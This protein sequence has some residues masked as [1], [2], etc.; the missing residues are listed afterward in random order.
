MKAVRERQGRSFAAGSW[1]FHA[2][3]RITILW[4]TVLFDLDGTLID[5]TEG[6]VRSVQYALGTVGKTENDLRNLRR[7]LGAPLREAFQE[8]AGL[9]EEEAG[10]ASEA[11]RDYFSRDGMYIASVYPGIPEMLYALKRAG[12]TLG[13]VTSKETAQAVR[14]LQQLQLAR[15]FDVII[16]CRP[17]ETNIPKGAL[18][19]E[20][21]NVL[22]KQQLRGEVVFVGDRF[23]DVQAAHGAGIAAAG[24]SYGYGTAGELAQSGADCVA[25]NVMGL[26]Q[27]LMRGGQMVSRGNAGAPMTTGQKILEVM[28]PIL[29]WLAITNIVSLIGGGIY[30]V[31][32]VNEYITGGGDV[33]SAPQVILQEMMQSDM[34]M[35]NMLL[36]GIANIISI[37]VF[38]SIFKKDTLRLTGRRTSLKAEKK[39][40]AVN[41]LTALFMGLGIS[42]VLNIIIAMTPIAQWMYEMNPGRYDMLDSL[43]LWASFIVTCLLAP[44][45]EELLFRALVFRRMR[46]FTGYMTAAFVSAAIFGFVHFDVVTG[47]AAFIIGVIM[48]MLYEYTGSIFTSMFF[49]FG[50]NLYATLIELIPFDS[51]SETAQGTVMLI[52]LLAGA[53]MAGVTLFIFLKKNRNQA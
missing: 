1:V 53:V 44:V 39:P 37:P 22:G 52:I 13:V 34:N 8:Y 46:R 3:E 4:K 40:G 19:E 11:Y 21:L 33:S 51:M 26:A 25:G 17:E 23:Y 24:V 50:F 32:K 41:T 36:S 18:I 12:M 28:I 5:S 10:R 15:C 47:I 30:G 27:C 38:F 14:I 16:G 2:S 35:I 45:A 43:P 7:Y 6:M 48:A 29:L 31:I 42:V 49:H 9:S 20:A